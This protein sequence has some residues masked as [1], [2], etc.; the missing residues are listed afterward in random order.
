MTRW[1]RVVGNT[2]AG[3][4]HL[5]YRL[6]DPTRAKPDEHD[7]N[8]PVPKEWRAADQLLL[9]LDT[10]GWARVGVPL[11]KRAITRVVPARR[12]LTGLV[13]TTGPSTRRP[14]RFDHLSVPETWKAAGELEVKAAAAAARAAEVLAEAHQLGLAIDHLLVP[15]PDDDDDGDEGW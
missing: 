2:Y 12:R 13:E 14:G 10:H 7:C 3:H 5:T 15:I 8:E 9:P 11:S 4:R 6:L 1:L